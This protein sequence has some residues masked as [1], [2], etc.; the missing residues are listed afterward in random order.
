[1]SPERALMLLIYVLVAAVLVI[2]V[3]NLAGKVD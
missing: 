2:V 3:L 1:M